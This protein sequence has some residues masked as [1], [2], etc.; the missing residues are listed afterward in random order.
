[1]GALFGK[2]LFQVSTLGVNA[3]EFFS[4]RNDNT[5]K[6]TVW[7]VSAVIKYY[8][9]LTYFL[10]SSFSG[11]KIIRQVIKENLDQRMMISQRNMYFEISWSMDAGIKLNWKK[12][13]LDIGLEYFIGKNSTVTLSTI[14]LVHNTWLLLKFSLNSEFVSL[15]LILCHIH[16]RNF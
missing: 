1:M 6:K 2:N 7:K 9:L 4:H 12:N 3:D 10:S 16:A 5:R 8:A 11:M 13:Q 15:D 14:L